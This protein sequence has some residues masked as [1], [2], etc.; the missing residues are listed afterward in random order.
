M[1]WYCD[2]PHDNP[3]EQIFSYYPPM[4]P[5]GSKHF[6][7]QYSLTHFWWSLLVTLLLKFVIK[8]TKRLVIVQIVLISIIFEVIENSPGHIKRFQRIEIDSS[9]KTNYRG[10]SVINLIGDIMCNLLGLWVG[11]TLPEEYSVL[12]L[13][14]LVP[15]IT[16]L[17]GEKYW[18]EFFS[19]LNLW[20]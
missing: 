3:L 11:V 13:V 17:I 2:Q 1:L 10:D 15:I 8:D 19:F 9:G 7:D 6:L 14:V 20:N 18:M 16:V 5:H 12:L 4:S